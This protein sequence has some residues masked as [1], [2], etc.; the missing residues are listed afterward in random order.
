MDDPIRGKVAKVLN[1]REIAI[2]LGSE[3][4]VRPGMYFDVV[5]PYEDIVDPDTRESL[6]AI[7]RPKFR[8]KITWVQEK[9]SLASTYR[10]REVNIGGKPLLG[11]FSRLLMPPK[12]VKKYDTFKTTEETGEP[13]GDSE[14]LVQVGDT[15]VQVVQV[16]EG[17]RV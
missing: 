15:V 4:G 1:S 7:E 12:W 3:Q 5:A 13:L 16:A 8:V 6:G 2:N 14:S 10:I 9:L 17:E 11:E